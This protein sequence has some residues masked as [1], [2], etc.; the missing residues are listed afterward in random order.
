MAQS[1]RVPSGSASDGAHAGLADLGARGTEPAEDGGD[2]D[3]EHV[4]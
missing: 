3:D 1:Q 4:G 2:Q